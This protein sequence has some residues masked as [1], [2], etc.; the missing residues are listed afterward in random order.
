MK[1]KKIS[2]YSTFLAL[3]M[4]SA[5]CSLDG[6]LPTDDLQPGKL[7]LVLKMAVNPGR[8]GSS[9]ALRNI[10]QPSATRADD[11]GYENPTSIYEG[12]RSLRIIIVRLIPDKANPE[13]S[14]QEVVE[15]NAYYIF[16]DNQTIWDAAKEYE[17]LVEGGETKRIYLIANE[18]SVGQEFVDTL[19][20]M[21]EGRAFVKED[22]D[23]E[24][25]VSENGVPYIDNNS[26]SGRRFIPMTEVFD[27]KIPARGVNQDM[28]YKLENSLFL[29][30]ALSKFSFSVNL[31]GSAADYGIN[32]MKITSIKISGKNDTGCFTDEVWLFPHCL[33]SPDGTAQI[34]GGA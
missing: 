29:T 13:N 15:H 14:P 11:Y 4:L 6:P 3:G 9:A 5:G 30:R 8:A 20:G 33:V 21:T 18:A 19:E 1:L 7:N 31:A 16:P 23:N 34:A 25:L 12:V 2:T 22:L 24:M 10:A 17:Y 32:G 28:K 27:A 26:V